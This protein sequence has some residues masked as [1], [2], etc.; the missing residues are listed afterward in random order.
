[1]RLLLSIDKPSDFFR[2]YRFVSTLARNDNAR[3]AAFRRDLAAL[4]GER[5]ALE[6]RTKES[7]DLRNR[8]V[9]TR[10]SLDQQ[11]ARKTELLTS[12]VEKK[13][14]N[15]AYVEELAQAEGR[16]QQM[17]G[18]LGG[19][20]AVAVPMGAFRGSLPWPVEGK[21]LAGFGR[22]KHPRFDTYTVHN[23][24]EIEAAPGTP[25][26][27][28]H[29]GTVVFADRFRGYGLLVVIDHGGKHHSLYAQLGEAAVSQGQAV[30]AGDVVGTAGEGGGEG[31]GLY[32]E[33]RYQGR[34]EDPADWLR[35]P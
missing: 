19:D 5:A 3:V 31:P 20:D 35:R 2:G 25:V 24:L 29:E 23:G 9:S 12:L 15:A 14:T 13:E 27:A 17:L 28:V 6:Q 33:M 7:I 11:R 22:R 18:G 34:A 16:L 1:V 4:A 8:L 21:V 30:A 26:C 10:R 32:F